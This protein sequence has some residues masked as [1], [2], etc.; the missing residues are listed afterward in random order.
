MFTL[1]VVAL[2]PRLCSWRLSVGSFHSHMQHPVHFLTVHV[3]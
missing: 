1:R 3:R 2:V